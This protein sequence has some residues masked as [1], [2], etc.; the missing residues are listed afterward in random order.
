MA[1]MPKP[2]DMA[3]DFVLPSTQGEIR[4]SDLWRDHIVVLTFYNEDNTPTCTRQVSTFVEEYDPFVE[5][6]AAV[7]AVSADDLESHRA[8]AENIGDVPFPLVSDTELK[9]AEL[10]GVI[11]DSG[12]RTRRAVFLIDKGG[13]IV[14]VMPWYNPTV[15][16]QY[17]EVV[18]ALAEIKFKPEGE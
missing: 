4:L 18:E 13:K 14:H 17:F 10:Y 11:D 16:A 8:F 2:K 3:P 1:D 5:S 12:K 6:G 9:A 7:V 15:G